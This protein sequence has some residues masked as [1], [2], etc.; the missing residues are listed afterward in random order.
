MLTHPLLNAPSRIFPS[1]AEFVFI[2]VLYVTVF[3]CVS[4]HRS[5]NRYKTIQVTSKE[6]LDVIAWLQNLAS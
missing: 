3:R 5:I 2:L 4:Q 6:N 1:G